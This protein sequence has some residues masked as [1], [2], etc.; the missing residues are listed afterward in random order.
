MR[1]FQVSATEVPRFAFWKRGNFRQGN[2]R[3]F[4]VGASK[5]LGILRNLGFCLEFF[6]VLVRTTSRSEQS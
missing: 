5:N 3:R 1:K 6:A 2:F 4:Q